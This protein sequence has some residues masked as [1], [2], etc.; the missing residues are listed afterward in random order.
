[1]NIDKIEIKSSR[2]KTILI[3]FLFISCAL[4]IVVLFRHSLLYLALILWWIALIGFLIDWRYRPRI[5]CLTLTETQSHKKMN[6]LYGQSWIN[7]V[8]IKRYLF[9]AGNIYLECEM[10][11]KN[12]SC[13]KVSIW[14][15]KDNF[16]SAQDNYA[17]V[18]FLMLS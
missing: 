14:L 11:F 4:M 1:M 13:K 2:L 16:Y 10:G 7:D 12:K 17:L 5:S 18:R 15:F 9:L 6:I 8:R 3:A